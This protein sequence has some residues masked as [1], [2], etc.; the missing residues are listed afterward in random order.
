MNNKTIL[1]IILATVLAFLGA[2]F[3]YKKGQVTE[4]P[5]FNSEIQSEQLSVEEN[6][7]KIDEKNMEISK[8]KA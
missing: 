8:D 3:I 6:V 7:S 4:M 5:D 2:L 1:V